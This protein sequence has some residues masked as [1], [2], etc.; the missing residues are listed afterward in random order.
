MIPDVSSNAT[1]TLTFMVPGEISPQQ[2]VCQ[3]NLQHIFEAHMECILMTLTFL[4][5]QL[6][7]QNLPL[8][9]NM[10]QHLQHGLA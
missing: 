3:E 10:F 1:M 5:V 7:G 8:S 2:I 9:C 6:A 4:I